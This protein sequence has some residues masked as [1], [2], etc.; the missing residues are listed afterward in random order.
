MPTLLQS[1][2]RVEKIP[3]V[4]KALLKAFNTTAV[5]DITLLAGGLSASAVYKIIINGIPY[6]LKLDNTT[7]NNTSD[8]LTCMEIAAN[9]GVA[10]QVYYLNIAEGISITGFIKAVPLASIF[11]SVEARLQE[12]AKTIKSIHELPLFIK[13]SSLQ[14]TVDGLINQFKA[15]RMLSGPV[16]DECFAYYD[17]IRKHYPWN[18]TDKVSSHN[19]LNPNNM[20]FDGEKIWI[21]DWDAAFR[22][23]RY[24]DLAITANFYVANDEHEQLFL[25][26]YFGDDLNDYNCARFFLMRQVCRLVYAMLMFKLADTSNPMGMGHDPVMQGINLNDVKQQIGAGKISLAGYEGQ[27]LFGKALFNEALASM[28][29]P[30]FNLSIQQLNGN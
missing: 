19:D 21:I 14:D 28:Q 15:S 2:I 7:P 3:A 13:E 29:S 18:D 17:L 23:D 9:G 25:Q 4:E 11:T 22:N 10:P 24:V 8:E 26:T 6:V 1:I 27:L 16:F 12:L 30:R 20:V 5:T